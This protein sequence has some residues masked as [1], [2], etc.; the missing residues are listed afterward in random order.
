MWMALPR[1]G[2]HL[3]H[4]TAEIASRTVEPQ[5]QHHERIV[6]R[7]DESD[8]SLRRSSQI[9]WCIRL[10]KSGLRQIHRWYS[11]PTKDS[12]HEQHNQHPTASLHGHVTPRAAKLL[13]QTSDVNES[14]LTC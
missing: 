2:S 11:R 12:C 10:I 8:S 4:S 6:N 1:H 13:S 9:Y 3:E 7:T 14:R 5:P